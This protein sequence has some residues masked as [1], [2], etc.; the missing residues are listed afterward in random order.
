LYLSFFSQ[1]K[2]LSESETLLTLGEVIEKS[3]LNAPAADDWKKAA[4][5]W[6]MRY[7]LQDLREQGEIQYTSEISQNST[8]RNIGYLQHEGD[9]E[10]I[11]IPATQQ[12]EE[13]APVDDTIQERESNG[14]NEFLI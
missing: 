13:V 6:Q 11:R 3:L 10:Y 5:A 12:E 7:F 9:L 4:F 8:L 2:I 14:S 1:L